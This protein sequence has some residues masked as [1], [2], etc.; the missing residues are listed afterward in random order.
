MRA[1]LLVSLLL[2]LSCSGSGDT[3]DRAGML[4][5][6]GQTVIL[7]TYRD[8]VTRTAT[9]DDAA[10]ALCA[11]PDAT[12][13]ASARQAYAAARVPLA[14]AEAFAIGPHTDSPLR[15]SPKV[16]FWPVR[17]D[18]VE[19]LLATD[20]PID[21]DATGSAARGLPAIGYVLNG[22]AQAPAE[23]DAI[24]AA[25][26]GRRCDYLRALTA[27]LE[28]RANEYVTAWSPEGDDFAGQLA[29][30]RGTFASVQAASSV[31]V[32]QLV[33]TTENV[34]E[35]EIGKPFGKRD[36]GV[37]QLDQQED[38]FGGRSL[39]DAWDAVRSVENVWRGRY[40]DDRGIGIRDWLLARRPALEPMVEQSFADVHAAFAALGDVTLDVAIAENPTGV[41]EVYQQ[42]KLLQT[43][44][45]VEVAQA[46]AVTVTF[47]PTDGD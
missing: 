13:L 27:N 41:E 17:P 15:L 47:N 33:F 3:F 4:A 44:L 35:L 21:V 24:L 26:P 28:A 29:E 14:Q 1:L 42:I 40:G 7:P 34:R 18:L 20:T 31:M 46:L 8:F 38:R 37:L 9:L 30:G 36:A 25:L 10:T 5:S 45:A 39:A 11:S 22:L 6:L 2:S 23:D 16:N 19:E 12:T 32:E 43:I